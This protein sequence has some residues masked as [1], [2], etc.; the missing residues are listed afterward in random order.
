MR[1]V[2]NILLSLI[3]I[4]TVAGSDDCS[5][6]PMVLAKAPCHGDTGNDARQG[7]ARQC[8]CALVVNDRAGDEIEGLVDVRASRLSAAATYGYSAPPAPYPAHGVQ[9]Q[10]PAGLP[11]PRSLVVYRLKSSFLI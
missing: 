10:R 7:L 9:L 4:G 6:C 1:I 3:L 2:A 5:T 11:H 8:C